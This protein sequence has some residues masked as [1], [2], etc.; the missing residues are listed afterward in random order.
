MVESRIMSRSP[1]SGKISL[2][3]ISLLGGGSSLANCLASVTFSK[4]SECRIRKASRSTSSLASISTS[5]LNLPKVRRIYST[6]CC[7]SFE[8]TV[9]FQTLLSM[10]TSL[11]RARAIFGDLVRFRNSAS[12]DIGI[13]K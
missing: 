5:A 7:R 10:C 9:D 13:H 3:S 8:V 1:G 6:L 4:I 12:A 2:P 11:N